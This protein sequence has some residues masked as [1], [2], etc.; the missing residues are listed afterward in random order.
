M[1]VVYVLKSLKTGRFYVGMSRDVL[2]RLSEHNSSRSRFTS[3]HIPWVLIYQEEFETSV[4]A[5]VRE[6]YLKTAA[7]K[8]YL[9]RKL[10]AGSLPD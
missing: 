4:E 3:G 5:R 6:K 10:D 1:W 2:K 9:K 8:R 7:G